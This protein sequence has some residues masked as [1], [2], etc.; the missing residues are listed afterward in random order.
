MPE[1]PA[2]GGVLQ[3]APTA[4]QSPKEGPLK[5]S[6]GLTHWSPEVGS[7]SVEPQQGT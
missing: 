4:A 3:Q 5:V 2:P 6:G 1:S 7:S